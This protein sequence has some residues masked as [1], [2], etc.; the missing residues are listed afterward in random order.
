M[1]RV[2][3]AEF[4]IPFRSAETTIEGNMSYDT[5]S[6]GQSRG[7]SSGVPGHYHQLPSMGSM[8]KGSHHRDGSTT[9]KGSHGGML[10]EFTKR[11]WVRRE[12]MSQACSKSTRQVSAMA[13]LRRIWNR[14]KDV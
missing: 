13:S 2:G 9:L 5:K 8:E 10:A 12:E 14:Q 1:A 3:G 6:M 4:E 11:T 7:N